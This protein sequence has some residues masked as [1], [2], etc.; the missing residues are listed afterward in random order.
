MWLSKIAKTG[1]NESIAEIGKITNSNSND[2]EAT[3][4]FSTRNSP[5]YSPYGIDCLPPTDEDVLMLSANGNIVALGTVSNT[6][7]LE[8]GEI[9]LHSAGGANI[10]LKNDGSVLINGLKIN[11]NG[12]IENG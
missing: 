5:L 12:V 11:S 4:S 10:V 9:R 6:S 3:T 8:S 1:T 2:V 7:S